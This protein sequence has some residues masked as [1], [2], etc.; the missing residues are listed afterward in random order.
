MNII[1]NED[2]IDNNDW[3]QIKKKEKK[4][5]NDNQNNILNLNNIIELILFVLIKY[6]PYSIYL[7]GS[8]A[9]CTNKIDSDVDILVFWKRNNNNILKLSEI[10]NELEEILKIKVDL[11]NMI[12]I[13][14]YMIENDERNKCYYDNIL[15]DAI[16]IYNKNIDDLQNLLEKSIKL[17]KIE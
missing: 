4:K 5:R 9:R 17:N 10:K 11:V 8:R 3:I 2:Y 7:Y 6:Q 14:K 12:Y 1:N 15:L 16:S 13:N